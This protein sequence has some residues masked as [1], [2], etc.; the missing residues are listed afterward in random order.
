MIELHMAYCS[1]CTAHGAL[2]EWKAGAESPIRR[3]CPLPRRRTAAT[4]VPYSG[5][6]KPCR[7][8]YISSLTLFTPQATASP[9]AREIQY[10]KVEGKDAQN[11]AEVMQFHARR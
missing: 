6:C 8:R 3:A 1:L 10:S 7:S 9:A 2:L 11:L 5:H 4:S